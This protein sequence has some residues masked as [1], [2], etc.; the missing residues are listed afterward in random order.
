[1]S[2]LKR[3]RGHGLLLYALPTYAFKGCGPLGL[4]FV[5]SSGY[6]LMRY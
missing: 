3:L 2:I 4:S 5:H 6:G 1:M